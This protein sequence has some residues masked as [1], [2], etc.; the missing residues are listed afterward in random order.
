MFMCS[1]VLSYLDYG[2]ATL[3]NLPKLTL[4]ALQSIQ[5]YAANVTH[6]KQKYDRSTDCLSTLHQLPIHYR[7]IYKLITIMY[8]TLHENEPQ[9][10]AD[11][12]NIKTVDRMTR[13]QTSTHTI[14]QERDTR[15]QM[16]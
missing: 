9:Y 14:Q 6:K 7:C 10:L 11:K 1:M 13:Y 8:K 3:V 16:I 2:N 15:G 5:N 4:K 12:L